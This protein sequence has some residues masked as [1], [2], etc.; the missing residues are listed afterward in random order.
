MLEGYAKYYS[1]ELSQKIRRG[2]QDNARKRMNN[3]GNIPLGYYVDKA[4]GRLTVNPETAPYVQELF[5]EIARTETSGVKSSAPHEQR[6]SMLNFRVAFFC[7][8][9]IQNGIISV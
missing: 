6:R 2:Q 8:Y 1:A 7:T 9:G 4:T 5:P 3:G